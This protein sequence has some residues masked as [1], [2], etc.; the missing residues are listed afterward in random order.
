MAWNVLGAAGSYPRFTTG[1]HGLMT[2]MDA[3]ADAL[4]GL[5]QRQRR[6]RARLHAAGPKP[7]ASLVAEVVRLRGYARSQ[8]RQQLTSAWQRSVDG[9]MGRQSVAEQ[10]RLGRIRRGVL[11]VWV[12][13]SAVNQ[14][15]TF[16]KRLILT[17]LR[18]GPCFECAQICG[19]ALGRLAKN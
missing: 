4:Y 8:S 6:E 7:V 9:V 11:E 1:Q 2:D 10:C 19:F 5:A 18:V 15:L 16:C 14:E 3:I 13:N 17:R 12:A